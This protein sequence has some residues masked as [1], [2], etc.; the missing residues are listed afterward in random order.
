MTQGIT[1][2]YERFSFDPLAAS[3]SLAGPAFVRGTKEKMES[4]RTGGT[5]YVLRSPHV[6]PTVRPAVQRCSALVSMGVLFFLAGPSRGHPS[7]KV[8]GLTTFDITSRAS[9][10]YIFN[11]PRL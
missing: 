7:Q 6:P 3:L 8:H 2:A 4:Q 10:L 11:V 9:H 1:E 5:K